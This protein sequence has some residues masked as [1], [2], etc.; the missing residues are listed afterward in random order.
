MMQKMFTSGSSKGKTVA[1]QF[2]APLSN[3]RLQI[4]PPSGLLPKRKLA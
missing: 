1:L 4:L 3:S 2:A